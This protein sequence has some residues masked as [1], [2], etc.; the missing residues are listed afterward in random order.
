M[1]PASIIQSVYGIY[2]W[3]EAEQK[4]SQLPDYREYM[5]DHRLDSVN[6]E[7]GRRIKKPTSTRADVAFDAEVAGAENQTYG[8][9]IAQNPSVANALTSSAN[10]NIMDARLNR[11]IQSD[12]ISAAYMGMKSNLAKEYQDI[13]N[14]NV[15][16]FNARLLEEERALGKAK[17]DSTLNLTEGLGGMMLNG[18][19]FV[20]KEYGG[21]GGM[22]DMIESLKFLND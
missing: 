14:K 10:P 6:D 17:S 22:Y 2:R 5:A 20:P 16:G 21:T 18:Q 4:M 3:V 7:A 11:T 15:G 9:S 19:D 12:G 1:N 13:S 8:Q